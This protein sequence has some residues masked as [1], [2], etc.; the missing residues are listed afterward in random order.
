MVLVVLLPPLAIPS[1]IA[2]QT[3]VI[4][5]TDTILRG[6]HRAPGSELTGAL[7]GSGYKWTNPC[8]CPSARDGHT[9][10]YDSRADRF[11]LF[12]GWGIGNETWSYDLASNSWSRM[13]G[14]NAPSAR[15]GHAA[16]YDSRADRVIL[17][18]GQVD[19][20]TSRETWAYDVE[21]DTW[22]NLTP[23]VGPSPRAGAGMAYD[24]LADRI[25]LFGG[26]AGYYGYARDTWVFDY[27]SD[28]WTNVTPTETSVPSGRAAHAMAYDS[29]ADRTILF[30]GQA[31]S[32]IDETW[33]YDFNANTWKNM[34]PVTK[35]SWR[36]WLAMA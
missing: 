17:F 23:Q 3:V 18:G 32:G 27:S 22:T 24:A 4:G 16:V 29:R 11:I 5:E 6:V 9:M 28:I 13:R 1:G 8:G 35:P 20:A 30:G 12:G 10:V 25:I 14:S 26:T 2:Q 36:S 7:A 33:A 15:G 19:T 31:I 34:N 21:S